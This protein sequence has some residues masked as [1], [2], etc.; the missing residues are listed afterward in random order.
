[1]KNHILFSIAVLMLAAV[2][3]IKESVAAGFTQGGED[4]DSDNM[5]DPWELKHGLNPNDP[6]D[7]KQD[8]DGDTFS[9]LEEFEAKTNPKDPDSHPE[10]LEYLSL[11]SDLRM[12]VLPFTFTKATPIPNGYRLRFVETASD[13][14]RKPVIGV[15]TAEI[16][17]EIVFEPMMVKFVKGRMQDNK[18]KSGWRVLRYNERNEFVTRKGARQKVDVSTVDIE[19]ISDKRKLS[20]QI[21]ARM[22]VAVEEQIDLRWSRGEG[23]TITVSKGTRFKLIN[24]EYEVKELATDGRACK[25]TIVDIA[26]KVD[27]IIDSSERRFLVANPRTLPAN[28]EDSSQGSVRPMNSHDTWGASSRRRRSRRGESEKSEY[29]RVMRKRAQI[30]ELMQAKAWD[31]VIRLCEGERDPWIV[32]FSTRPELERFRKEKEARLA[33][34]HEAELRRQMLSL[35]PRLVHEIVSRDLAAI[36][37]AYSAGHAYTR[38]YPRQG[39]RRGDDSWDEDW[40]MCWIEPRYDVSKA[41]RAVGEEILQ[42]FGTKHLP[43]AYANY[44]KARA[45]AK[46]LQEVFNEEFVRPWTIKRGSPPW[47]AFDTFLKK[48]A[49]ARTEYFLCH[50][51]LCHYWLAWRFGVITAEDFVKI[52]SQK[53][54]VPLLPEKSG[55]S[56]INLLEWQ[57]MEEKLTVFAAKYATESHAIYQ[58]LAREVSQLDS[59]LKEIERQRMQMDYVGSDPVLTAVVK[60]RNAVVSRADTLSSTIHSWYM[61]HRIAEKSLEDVA[62]C[63]KEKSIELRPFLDSLPSYI[64]KQA[65]VLEERAVQECSNIPKP[66]PRDVISP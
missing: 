57:P 6:A 3:A 52:D 35:R 22:P 60:K 24:R 48:F 63:D 47:N 54:A 37:R 26:N 64:Q 38:P 39:V 4:A 62:K 18:V 36:K 46:C 13:Q 1:M 32:A 30:E 33:A 15:A 43:N 16:G 53:L 9:N 21:G 2:V 55:T 10:V 66:N 41:D 23:R 34:E 5:S 17:K 61:D 11:A 56:R 7:A 31:E 8:S 14:D 44:E 58:K 50:D 29:E 49:K 27:W 51:E 28:A 20:I 59:L 12:D 25:V 65:A 40:L 42:K 19:R 45:R